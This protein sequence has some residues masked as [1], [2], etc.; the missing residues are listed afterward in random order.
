MKTRIKKHLSNINSYKNF[1]SNYTEVSFHFGNEF[2]N[3]ETD[4]RFFVFKQVDTDIKRK[5]VEADLIAV[6]TKFGQR[7]LNS[8]IPNINCL[9]N[10]SF[11]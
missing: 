1:C 9:K 3:I 11:E 10:L 2:H 5:N 8:F 4:F 7:L 6:F